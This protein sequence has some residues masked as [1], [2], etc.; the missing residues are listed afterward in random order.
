[1]RVCTCVCACARERVIPIPAAMIHT[2]INSKLPCMCMHVCMGI[3]LG[4]CAYMCTCES[5]I[6]C[7]NSYQ[8][9][10]QIALYVYACVHVYKFIGVCAYMCQCVSSFVCLTSYQN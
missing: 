4:V 7:H 10:Q 3:S 2:R 6:V 1:M 9:Q 8:N 5:S